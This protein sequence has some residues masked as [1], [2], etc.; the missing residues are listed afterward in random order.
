M[1]SLGCSFKNLLKKMILKEGSKIY[2]IEYLD[3]GRSPDNME[4]I[5]KKPLIL[6]CC[7]YIVNE[8]EDE[9]YYAL[10]SIGTRFREQKPKMYNYVLKRAITKKIV[11]HV[12]KN[13]ET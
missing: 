12:V 7:G 5:K 13:H 2:F 6:W 10:I 4:E 3:H 11:I 1:F 8:D 9:E